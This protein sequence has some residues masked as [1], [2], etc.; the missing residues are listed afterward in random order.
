M[1]IPTKD[2]KILWAKA[3]GRCSMPDCRKVLVAEASDAVPS[4][5]TLIGE[6]CHIIGEKEASSRGRSILNDD[7]RNRYPN[8][9]LLCRIHHKIIDDDETAWP[10]ERLHTIKGDH[11]IWV[12]TA[13]TEGGD[14]DEE[15]YSAI[16]NMITEKLQLLSWEGISDHALRGMLLDSFVAGVSDVS[17]YLFKAIYPGVKQ[18][19]E[20]KIINLNTRA[21]LYTDHFVSN[22][23]LEVGNF[24]RGRRFY[25]EPY[26]NPNYH[27]DLQA[28]N[29]WEVKCT[30]LLFNLVYA[31]NEFADQ[32]RSDIKPNYFKLQGK[33]VVLDSMGVLGDPL[34]FKTFMPTGYYSD[35][36]LDR[37]KEDGDYAEP[38]T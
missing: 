2:I 3:A 12:E 32:V 38:V 23:S 9:I 27:E 24:Y 19:L 10:V 28:Y 13:L 15:W 11:E 17:L 25:R 4:K 26:P 30:R 31:L 21:T 36:I 20:N 35:E 14:I 29:R 33:F 37:L 6:N 8:L 16:I 5:S 34:V 7:D 22:A 18:E 1:T